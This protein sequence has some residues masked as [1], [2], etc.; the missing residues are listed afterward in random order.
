M[1]VV[2]YVSDQMHDCQ[3][4]HKSAKV[5]E[6]LIRRPIRFI[7]KVLR[8]QNVILFAVPHFLLRWGRQRRVVVGPLQ[9]VLVSSPELHP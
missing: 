9:L 1:L 4:T 5:L 3:S 6:N 7:G 2:T 8:E